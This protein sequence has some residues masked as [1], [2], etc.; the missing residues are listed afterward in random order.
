MKKILF[1]A[2]AT[3]TVAYAAP[4]AAANDVTGT[5]TINGSVASKCAVVDSQG[6]GTGS[7]ASTVE[8]GELSGTDGK[9]KPSA[10]L[11]TTFN[12]GGSSSAQLSF[13]LVCTT[14]A[15]KVTLTANPIVL[16]GAVTPL[17][18]YDN[19][20]NYT[21]KAAF[22]TTSGAQ[23]V[24]NASSTGTPTNATLSAPLAGGSSNNLTI[25]ADTFSTPN[26]GV[27]MAGA[28]EGTVVV[29]ISPL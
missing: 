20:V 13:R 23:N 6:A 21:A 9:L 5:I 10:D 11:S 8:M 25:T 2:L 3:T 22:T 17:T 24:T 12:S 14:A 18:G 1:A 16:S 7:F 19:R 27:M 4:A 29:N 28:Y 15:P 26:A